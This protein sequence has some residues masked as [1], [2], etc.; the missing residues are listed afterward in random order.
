MTTYALNA[1]VL[2][3]GEWVRK[4]LV[5]HWV[6]NP[7]AEPEQVEFDPP[8]YAAH[9]LIACPFCLARMD[10]SC[11]TDGGWSHA[12]RLLKRVCA[13]GGPVRPREPMCGFCRAEMARS[14]VA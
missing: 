10:E 8:T 7:H 6:A 3:D 12:S 2:T 1:D 14:D 4:G 11:K 13:C 9:E 5:W